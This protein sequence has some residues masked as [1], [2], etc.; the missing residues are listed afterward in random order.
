MVTHGG[1]VR[2]ACAALAGLLPDQL[3]PVGNT[4]ITVIELGHGAGR[5][6]AFGVRAVAPAVEPPPADA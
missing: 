5:L 6:A 4:S 3:V 2:A 1:P